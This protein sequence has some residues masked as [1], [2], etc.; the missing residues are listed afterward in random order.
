MIRFIDITNDYWTDLV[1]DGNPQAA[2][3]STSD[4]TFLRNLDG[5]HIFNDLD[6]IAEHRLGD[7][8]L[9]LV[10][11]GFF[12]REPLVKLMLTREQVSD[13]IYALE[14]RVGHVASHRAELIIDALKAQVPE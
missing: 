9:A 8:M 11:R 6:E 1:P 13:I 5:G 12:N 10:P 14:D 2:F 3:I 4:D 7:R